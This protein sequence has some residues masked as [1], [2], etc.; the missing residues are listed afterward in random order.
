[1]N[2]G[3]KPLIPIRDHLCGSATVPL[4]EWVVLLEKEDLRKPD[5]ES[6][7]LGSYGFIDLEAANEIIQVAKYLR[8]FMIALSCR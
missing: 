2:H 5:N 1:M 4:N 6:L 7:L 3:G 8:S